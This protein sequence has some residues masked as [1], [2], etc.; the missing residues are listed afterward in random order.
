[1]H[2]ES[3]VLTVEQVLEDLILDVQVFIRSRATHSP[4]SAAC[5]I[6]QSADVPAASPSFLASAVQ[7]DGSTSTLNNTK[8]MQRVT[9]SHNHNTLIAS[10][11]SNADMVLTATNTKGTAALQQQP[12]AHESPLHGLVGA[13]SWNAASNDGTADTDAIAQTSGTSGEALQQQA[14]ADDVQSVTSANTALRHPDNH[15]NRS[16][17]LLALKKHRLDSLSSSLDLSRESSFDTS[18]F[19][20]QQAATNARSVR[21]SLDSQI[22]TH[23]ENAPTMSLPTALQQASPQNSPPLEST[24]GEES[25][26]NATRVSE[27]ILQCLSIWCGI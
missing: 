5:E 17:K 9:A 18:T 19:S 4:D 24:S 12:S 25:S 1:M 6:S 21:N 14:S 26:I 16:S 10:E 7:P 20:I 22:P 2:S 3:D 8:S 23:G 13:A 27:P 11:S 15:D